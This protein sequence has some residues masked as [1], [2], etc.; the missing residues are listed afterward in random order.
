MFG[1]GM[2]RCLLRLCWVRVSG[3]GLVCLVFIRRCL[4]G[5]CML[6]CAGSLVA[7]LTALE[8]VVGW[9]VGCGFRLFGVMCRCLVWVRLRCVC[10]FGWLVMVLCRWSL[11]MRAA[12]R[13]YR[14]AR[15]LR[16]LSML[17]C[18]ALVVVGVRSRCSLWR[19]R[20]WRAP[21]ALGAL[22]L[23]GVFG[24]CW[25][26]VVWLVVWGMLVWLLRFIA[27]WVS[28]LG[29]SRVVLMSRMSFSLT[30]ARVVV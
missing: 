26:V 12:R 28:W 16:G 19:G 21:G 18:W 1:G 20:P 24:R 15:L 3:S 8:L 17:G 4:M 23:L 9:V 2:V 5:R 6:F 29:V 14:S 30:W 25:V 13:C 7:T 22:G 27:I 11:L 10:V